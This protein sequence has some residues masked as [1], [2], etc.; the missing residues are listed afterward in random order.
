VTRK[1][2]VHG[3]RVEIY[4]DRKHWQ[5]LS[6]LRSKAFELM[7][8][9][10]RANISV[11]T[12]GSVA[13]GDVN[14]SSDIDIFL[15]APSSS[16][17]IELVLER[18]GLRPKRRSLIQATPYYAVKGY[19]EVDE[20]QVVSF[21]LMRMRRVERE[22][23]RY[24]GEITLEMLRMNKRVVGVDKRLMLIEPTEKGH[25]ESA[26]VGEE[27]ETARVLHVS[28]ETVLDRVHALL[29]REKI[30]RTGV[31]IE[32]VLPQDE[33]FEG[34]LKKLVE[35]RPEVKRRLRSHDR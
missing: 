33:T 16:F 34:A 15:P 18:A 25:T 6:R 2:A 24:G 17:S 32:R 31:F 23:Y 9:L 29:R 19:I 22:F 28:T 27:E 14:A 26:I 1:L 11:V 10:E 13:R 4:Y 20:G 30:G 8:V 35:S 7:E 3:E 5:H 12:H 21:P